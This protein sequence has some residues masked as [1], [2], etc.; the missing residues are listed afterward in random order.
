MAARMVCCKEFWLR[1]VRRRSV[2]VTHSKTM[3]TSKPVS[4]G[5]S[6]DQE[7]DDAAKRRD[8]YR[9][10]E[11]LDFMTATKI[12]LTVPPKR[13]KF[14]L[15][16]HLVQLFFCCLPSLAVYLV[17]QYAQYEMR[18]M[19]AELEAKRKAEEEAKAIKLAEERLKGPEGQILEVKER[20]DKLENAI[21]EIVVEAKTEDA[22]KKGSE[23]AISAHKKVDGN[24]DSRVVEA[25]TNA[26]ASSASQSP[27]KD[28][29]DS[30][31]VEP[32]PRSVIKSEEKQ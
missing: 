12:L 25:K 4:N 2:Q 24:T 28:S 15:D 19:E 31:P 23:E 9:Q 14:G 11:N 22:S 1:L 29:M 8:A 13:K 21:K 18:K 32:S 6:N 10:L 5:N 16:F 20:L 7:M 26:H 27:V 30:K 3:C 17:A